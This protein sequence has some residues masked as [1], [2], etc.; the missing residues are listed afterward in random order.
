MIELTTNTLAK[1]I[2]LT[3][4]DTNGF[5]NDNYFTMIPKIPKN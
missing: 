3:C 5:F 4:H 2:Y 1:N